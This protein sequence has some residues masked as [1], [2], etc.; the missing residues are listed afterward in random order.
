MVVL[1]PCTRQKI[2]HLFQSAVQLLRFAPLRHHR[3]RARPDSWSSSFLKFTRN[4]TVLDLLLARK[5]RPTSGVLVSCSSRHCH[6][7]STSS[8]STLPAELLLL[9]RDHLREAYVEEEPSYW[10]NELHWSAFEDYDDYEQEEEEEDW[11]WSTYWNEDR[12]WS[13]HTN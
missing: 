11:D 3:Q 5:K 2:A 12:K 7:A 1:L 13:A 10:F 8:L 4:A 9:V 6:L